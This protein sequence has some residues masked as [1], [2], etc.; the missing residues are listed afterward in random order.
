MITKVII[1]MGMGLSLRVSLKFMIPVLFWVMT[2]N[3]IHAQIESVP[4]KIWDSKISRSIFSLDAGRAIHSV[5]P[6]IYHSHLLGYITEGKL[7]L[8]S[9]DASLF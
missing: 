6:H 5:C 3:Y 8:V 7:L 2:N 9:I 4:V 1:S